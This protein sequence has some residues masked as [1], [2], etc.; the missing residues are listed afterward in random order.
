MKTEAKQDRI[1]KAFTQFICYITTTDWETQ[2]PFRKAITDNLPLQQTSGV[3]ELIAELKE[4]AW[5]DIRDEWVVQ[6]LDLDRTIELIKRHLTPS[7]RMK[8]SYPRKIM[9][10]FILSISIVKI[11]F[12]LFY[13]L[14]K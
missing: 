8:K 9:F 14:P 7:E 10:M 6:I 12:D 3:S 5:W 2:K 11:I 1:D 13:I 4:N